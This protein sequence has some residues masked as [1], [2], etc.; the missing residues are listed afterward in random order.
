M[1]AQGNRQKVILEIIKEFG[2]LTCAGIVAEL[3]IGD[4]RTVDAEATG[5]ILYQMVQAGLLKYST[6]EKGPKGGHVYMLGD[7]APTKRKFIL[8]LKF[9]H[10]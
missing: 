5:R 6:T 2:P 4:R 3:E 1:I 7:K 9:N 10:E 8:N